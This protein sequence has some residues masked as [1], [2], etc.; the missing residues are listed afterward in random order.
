MISF[1]LHR[2][3]YP[4]ILTDKV[5]TLLRAGEPGQLSASDY[6]I[7][8]KGKFQNTGRGSGYSS[9]DVWQEIDGSRILVETFSSEIKAFILDV[10]PR[11]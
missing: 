8:L 4:T 10:A 1:S 2:D 6:K 5:Q 7:L 11:K 9:G 3:S